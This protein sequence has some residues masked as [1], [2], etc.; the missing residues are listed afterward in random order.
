MSSKDRK[1][2]LEDFLSK[3]YVA[4]D[5]G[6]GKSK[7]KGSI[8]VDMDPESDAEII[9]NIGQEP[10]PLESNSVDR[11]TAKQFFEHLED[12]TPV[13]KE[14]YRILKDGGEIF[15][16]VPHYTS[17]VAHVIA[18]KHYFS[19]HEAVRMLK[20]DMGA[21]IVNAE[22]TFYKTF[23]MFGIKYLANKFVE[24]YERFWAYIFPAENIKVTAVVKKV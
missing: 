2:M 21:E 10:I 17:Y 23:R 24:N 11:V 8:G 6:C 14:V 22:I 4:V 12:P 5:L 19:L 13:L 9:I 15:I 18:H 20:Y 1:A 7:I 16:E 3:D